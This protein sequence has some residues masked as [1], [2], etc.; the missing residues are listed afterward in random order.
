MVCA[1]AVA[2]D[3]SNFAAVVERAEEVLETAVVVV[4]AGVVSSEGDAVGGAEVVSTAVMEVVRI[5]PGRV[6]VGSVIADGEG[7]GKD[8]SCA[9]SRT[10]AKRSHTAVSVLVVLERA[11]VV[12]AVAALSWSVTVA[13]VEAVVVVAAARSSLAAAATFVDERGERVGTPASSDALLC[14]DGRRA[15]KKIGV[16][17]D[18]TIFC[19]A[20]RNKNHQ[21][22]AITHTTTT[23]QPTNHEPTILPI[24]QLPPS[25]RT[26]PCDDATKSRGSARVLVACCC[27]CSW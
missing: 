19:S 3:N 21:L 20:G 25:Q 12:E 6:E 26:S 17:V 9:S 23:Y 27:C 18:V 22:P 24:H 10:A 13:A 5:S 14:E 4:V 7:C 15:K 16:R 8:E 11:E 1:A 2:V